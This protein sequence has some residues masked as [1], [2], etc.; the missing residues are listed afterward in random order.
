MEINFKQKDVVMI[1]Q[2]FKSNTDWTGFILRLTIGFILFPHG[3]QKVFGW[4]GGYG[5]EGTMS[6]FTSTMHIPWVIGILVILI[7]FIGSVFLIAGFATRIWAFAVITNM[8]GIIF[9]SHI[10]NGFFM[11]WFGNQAGEG[12]EYFLLVIGLSIA[13]LINGSGKYSVDKLI[14]R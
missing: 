6:F 5:F 11:N 4:F 3:A 1:K 9:S 2:I 10:Q 13:L 14:V 8:A 12:I 7:E